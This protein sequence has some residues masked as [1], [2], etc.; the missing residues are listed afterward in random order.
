M[1]VSV[2][3]VPDHGKRQL[4]FYIRPT[5]SHC[6]SS[7][8]PPTFSSVSVGLFLFPSSIFFPTCVFSVR[9]FV[10][11]CWPWDDPLVNFWRVA[12]HFYPFSFSLKRGLDPG[13]HFFSSPSDRLSLGLSVHDRCD[14]VVPREATHRVVAPTGT[15]SCLSS[16]SCDFYC[17]T[18]AS[19][20]LT[21][22]R[23]RTR[24]QTK[25]SHWAFQSR[26]HDSRP[27]GGK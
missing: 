13:D 2:I 20:G 18:A 25:K 7:S 21:S 3:F 23:R 1:D 15:S 22:H 14:S 11:F 19:P 16:Q 12:S 5:S 24:R 8:Q 26:L 6:A 4:F 17:P 9:A 10:F 27:R